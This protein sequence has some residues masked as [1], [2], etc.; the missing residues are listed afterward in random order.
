ML[1]HAPQEMAEQGPGWKDQILRTQNGAVNIHAQAY[2]RR[3]RGSDERCRFG[4]CSVLPLLC[5]IIC[6]D[7]DIDRLYE[8]TRT[9]HEDRSEP[10]VL[11]PSRDGQCRRSVARIIAGRWLFE[12][13]PG[14]ASHAESWPT[15]C[16]SRRS[17]QVCGTIHRP[18]CR[19]TA[20][21][22]CLR[23]QAERHRSGSTSMSR[24][25]DTL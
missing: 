8:S 22:C 12:R 3:C 15:C 25:S 6:L 14:Y 17:G 1:G 13:S 20:R 10:R 16:R 4:R 23:P 24:T 21:R 2:G 19:R 9:G 7:E 11:L 18:S 5:G